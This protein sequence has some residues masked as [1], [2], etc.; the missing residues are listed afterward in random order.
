MAAIKIC[1]HCGRPFSAGIPGVF[2]PECNSYKRITY[3]YNACRHCNGTGYDPKTGYPCTACN[4]T[5]KSRY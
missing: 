1:E 3:G 4:G 5:G 2:C